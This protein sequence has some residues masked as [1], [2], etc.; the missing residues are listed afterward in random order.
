MS[1]SPLILFPM[2]IG[3]MSHVDFKKRPCR[4]AEFKGQGPPTCPPPPPPHHHHHPPNTSTTVQHEQHISK[5]AAQPKTKEL[6]TAWSS[7]SELA[8]LRSCLFR[9]VGE[10]PAPTTPTSP[11]GPTTPD[12]L[13]PA[14]RGCSQGA[15]G[16]L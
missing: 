13:L 16:A 4:P 3:F 5:R 12:Y 9:P 1:T 2:S 11:P 15:L 10:H 7:S 14:G 8:T 6:F